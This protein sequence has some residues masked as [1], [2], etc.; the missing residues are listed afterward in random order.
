MNRKS[1][2]FSGCI[3]IAIF[4]FSFGVLAQE[5][6]KIINLKKG[7][8]APYEGALLNAKAQ[9]MI[10]STQETQQEDCDIQK[11]YELEKQ[12]AKSDLELNSS[13]LQ[14]EFSG[15]KLEEI[16]KIKDEEIKRLGQVIIKQ[17][18]SDYSKWWLAGGIV[19]G[20][21][22]TVLLT[23]AIKKVEQ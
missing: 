12:K 22:A 2:Y 1:K 4:F 10:L 17:E 7:Q 5:E 16:S 13:K 20:V 8:V 14:L 23:L 15:K 3:L 11:K 21:V 18:K 19:I 6:A 9:A